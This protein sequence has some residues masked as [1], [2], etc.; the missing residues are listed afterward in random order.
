MTIT[1]RPLLLLAILITLLLAA[2]SGG[3]E[4]PALGQPGQPTFVFVYTE[5]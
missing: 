5:N 1:R 4:T 3:T 2:C